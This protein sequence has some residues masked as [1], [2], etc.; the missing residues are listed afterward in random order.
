[1]PPRPAER[2]GRLEGRPSPQHLETGNHHEADTADRNA[3]DGQRGGATKCRQPQFIRVLPDEVALYGAAAAIVVA[4]IR[5]RTQYECQGRVQVDGAYWWRV[6]QTDLGR[7]V[8]LSR[9]Q[10]R[11]ALEALG[12]VVAAKHLERSDDRTWAYR[13]AADDNPADQP[14][15]ESNQPADLPLVNPNQPLVGSNQ[16]IGWIQPMHIYIRQGR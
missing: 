8:G 4:Q 6:S 2:E 12:D 11:S 16:T 15:V 9:Q 3:R 5:F 10:V 1:M 13:V 14:L 7:E